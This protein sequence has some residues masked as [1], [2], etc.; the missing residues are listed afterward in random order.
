MGLR[1]IF[2]RKEE[3]VVGGWRIQHNEELHN[4]DASHIIKL[5]KLRMRWVGH[6]AYV[7]QTCRVE[8]YQEKK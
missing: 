6:M 3:E 2:G 4:L 5:I 7:G 1:K 8:T